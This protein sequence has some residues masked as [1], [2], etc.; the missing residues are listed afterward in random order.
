MQGKLDKTAKS[1][2]PPFIE[3]TNGSKIQKTSFK[4]S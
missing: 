1:L 3:F 4:A 2:S